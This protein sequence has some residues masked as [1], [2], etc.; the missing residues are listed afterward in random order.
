VEFDFRTLPPPERYKLLI[1]LVVPRPIALVTTRAEDG[2]VNAAPFSFFNVFSQD[3]AVVAL[4][5]ERRPGTRIAKDTV[6]NIRARREF[7]VNLVDLAIAEAMNVCA[8]DFPPGVDE[9][10]A[11]GLAAVPGQ[12]V[13]VP[14]VA[15]APAALECRLMQEIRLG[16]EGKRSLVLGEILHVHVRDGLVD[17]RLHVDNA[18]FLGR[19]AGSGYA[20]L[21]DRFEMKRIGFEE[22]TERNAAD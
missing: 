11:A 7:V 3:P 2:V 21:T 10:A 9:L 22:W 19:L 13:D 8:V 18:G 6:L 17:E 1:G 4:G 16:D 20:R 12:A 5:I 15:E 14:R